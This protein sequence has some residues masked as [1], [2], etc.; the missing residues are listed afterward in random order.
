ME[1]PM[2][3]NYDFILPPSKLMIQSSKYRRFMYEYISERIAREQQDFRT[4]AARQLQNCQIPQDF[5]LFFR[6]VYCGWGKNSL[7]CGKREFSGP[8]CPSGN[9][10]FEGLVEHLLPRKCVMILSKLIEI[11]SEIC[12]FNYN[13][14][15]KLVYWGTT[16][17]WNV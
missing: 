8:G 14:T 16:T 2:K 17:L 15:I 3:A 6:L 13:K 4:Q 12:C 5:H 11:I 7:R 10:I 9:K 1:N